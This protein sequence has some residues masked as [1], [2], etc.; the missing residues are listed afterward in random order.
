MSMMRDDLFF[1]LFS[2]LFL[3]RWKNFCKKK[4]AKKKGRKKKVVVVVILF[5]DSSSVYFG[6]ENDDDDDDGERKVARIIVVVVVAKKKKT[7]KTQRRQEEEEEEDDGTAARGRA[8]KKPVLPEIIISVLQNH[9]SETRGRFCRELLALGGN[10]R[11]AGE[12]EREST[13]S[14]QHRA[15]NSRADSLAESVHLRGQRV[16]VEERLDEDRG[17]VRDEMERRTSEKIGV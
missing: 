10:V 15:K 16:L 14:S 8:P 2:S 4:K 6:E 5:F 9:Q 13:S 7:K 17:R 11:D 12:T 1:F 3:F